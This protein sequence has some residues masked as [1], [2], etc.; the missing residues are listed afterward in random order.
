MADAGA[1]GEHYTLLDYE[2]G[3][4]EALA[5]SDLV[6]ARAGASVFELAAAGRPAMLVPYPYATGRH[7]HANAEWMASAGAAEVIEDAELSG[8]LVWERASELLG[9]D[10]RLAEMAAASASL[11][12]PD[13]AERRCRRG[14][15]DAWLTDGRDGL[16]R[17]QA[18][19]HR[20]RRRRDERPGAG[21][22]PARRA[23]DRARTVPRAA[24]WTG[25]ARPG[26]ISGSGT[27]PTPC[28]PDA[29]VVVSTAI[30]DDNPELVRARER[31]QPALH[32]GALLAELCAEGRLIAVAG[33]HG[34]TTTTGMLVHALRE[35]GEDPSFFIGG[36]LPGAGSG[37]SAANAGR[38]EGDWVVAEADESD[39]SF[40][41]LRARDRRG[42]ERRAGPPRPVGVACRADRGVRSVR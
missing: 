40:L 27:M 25:C 15:R 24:T 20:D 26:S 13:A 37:G 35:L 38:G 29:E 16:D 39:A 7:Q 33:T 11:A 17:A 34:K 1:G 19:L 4:A 23:G 10:E 31:G 30:G 28:L 21:L 36:E 14:P 3:L 12:M 22:P 32:R 5:A 41:E 9:D 6:L 42:Y 8:E 18:P 2:P